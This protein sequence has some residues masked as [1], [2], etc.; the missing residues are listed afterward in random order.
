MI[1]SLS[2]CKHCKGPTLLLHQSLGRIPQFKRRDQWGSLI[3]IPCIITSQA[4]VCC[5]SSGGVPLHMPGLQVHQS[6][7]IGTCIALSEA[8]TANA[9]AAIADSLCHRGSQSL[10][11]PKFDCIVFTCCPQTI[12]SVIRFRHGRLRAN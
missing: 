10:L 9:A 7:Q 4:F 1:V 12:E 6:I 3:S 8:S 5:C 2:G 11:S